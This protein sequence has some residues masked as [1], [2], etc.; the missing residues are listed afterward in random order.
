MN[1]RATL[2]GLLAAVGFPSDDTQ[3]FVARLTDDQVVNEL[4]WHD[5]ER[6]MLDATPY[7]R[8]S[9]ADRQA[10]NA[11]YLNVHF[12]DPVFMLTTYP[13]ERPAEAPTPPAS[14]GAWVAGVAFVLLIGGAAWVA[15]RKR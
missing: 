2:A 11:H 6:A 3:R 9:P 1:S 5:H 10:V 7:S 12:V 14:G 4:R 15:G 8:W 13:G